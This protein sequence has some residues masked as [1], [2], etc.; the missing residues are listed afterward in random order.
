MI[1]RLLNRGKT[2]GRVDDN[3]ETIKKR[4]QTF[5]KHTKPVLDAYKS[6]VVNVSIDFYFL[7]YLIFLHFIYLSTIFLQIPADRNV[8]EIFQDICKSIDDLHE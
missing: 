7:P 3:E 8:I 6:I 5:H 4:L 1:S 2:S